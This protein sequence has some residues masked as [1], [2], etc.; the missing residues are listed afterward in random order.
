VRIVRRVGIAGVIGGLAFALYS[1][2]WF[3][4]GDKTIW[5]P[6]NLVAHTIWR[7]APTDG[8]F[9]AGAAVLGLITLAVVGVLALAP[10]AAVAV[11]VGMHPLVAI[12]GASIYANVIWIIGH[13]MVWERLD[14]TAAHGF[15]S[16]VAWAAHFVAG[17][18]GG[19]ALVWLTSRN[20][21]VGGK[22]G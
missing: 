19:A 5:Y 16:G 15:S 6:L 21:A 18:I 4:L 2:I 9:H 8:R 17:L 7:G 3:G 22:P 10:F 1:M 14:P 20:W 13:Y 11:L 12:V